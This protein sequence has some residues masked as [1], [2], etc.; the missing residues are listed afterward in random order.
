MRDAEL[1]AMRRRSEMEDMQNMSDILSS[2][3]RLTGDEE[4]DSSY[5]SP[6]IV[7]SDGDAH[8][9]LNGA[10]LS[11]EV[12]RRTAASLTRA[13]AAPRLGYGQILGDDDWS[14]VD[15][16]L[17]LGALEAATLV[18]ERARAAVNTESVNAE[19]V[20]AEPKQSK[21]AGAHFI[22]PQSG[23]NSA[24][25][26][27]LRRS[28]EALNAARIGNPLAKPP[29]ALGETRQPVDMRP[30]PPIVGPTRRSSPSSQNRDISESAMAAMDEAALLPSPAPKT[31][32]KPPVAPVRSSAESAVPMRAEER[33]SRGPVTVHEDPYIDGEPLGE[34]GVWE[35]FERVKKAA[36]ENLGRGP[37]QSSAEIQDPVDQSVHDER[38]GIS[39]TAPAEDGVES[40]ANVAN[41]AV[42][43]PS[44]MP[45]SGG[46]SA[47]GVVPQAHFMGDFLEAYGT[48]PAM[49][50]DLVSFV[51]S[52]LNIRGDRDE[53]KALSQEDPGEERSEPACLAVPQAQ[54][55]HAESIPMTT[56][57]IGAKQYDT[58]EFVALQL[59]EKRRMEQIKTLME[60][61]IVERQSRPRRAAQPPSASIQALIGEVS[62]P[63]RHATNEPRNSPERTKSVTSDAAP[64]DPKRKAPIAQAEPQPAASENEHRRADAPGG[65]REPPG[66]PVDAG[67]PPDIAALLKDGL[68]DLLG[69]V[70]RSEIQKLSATEKGITALR[71]RGKKDQGDA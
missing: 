71:K 64:K 62:P 24:K 70:V 69:E 18:A 10:A 36:K 38:A 20:E 37:S 49:V 15:G 11:P 13:T 5:R 60:R 26:S 40:V 8:A 28:Q 19:S 55:E 9:A 54:A 7:G 56:P 14:Q 65:V 22:E 35:S 3:R 33:Q 21:A 47:E 39:V 50:V 52:A 51:E 67:L 61:T 12:A 1:N 31:A 2:I 48:E 46:E 53:A 17:D 45:E 57:N 4:Q 41:E 43:S 23:Q 63:N 30:A 44:H 6:S 66:A 25:K 34:G 29:I 32:Q 16:A 27:L 68:R 58:D 42:S 59:D